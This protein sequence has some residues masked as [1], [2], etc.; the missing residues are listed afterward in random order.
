MM[1]R[2]R[3]ILGPGPVNSLARR[4]RMTRFVLNS[5]NWGDTL[6]TAADQ[7]R[8]FARIDLLVPERHRAYAR[9]LLASIVE[10]QRWGVPPE[11]PSGWRTFFKG[12]WRNGLINQSALIERGKRRIGLAVLTDG[13]PSQ[14]YGIETI[15]G[16]ARRLLRGL[17]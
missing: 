11:V 1:F 16:V 3:D 12:G 7:A 8:F 15:R 10:E 13:D 14:A 2:V 5:G 17:R 9:K 6:I 4:A